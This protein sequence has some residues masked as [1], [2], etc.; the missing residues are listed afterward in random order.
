MNVW[1]DAHPSASQLPMME[2]SNGETFHIPDLVGPLAPTYDEVGVDVG[3][4][5]VVRA[6]DLRRCRAV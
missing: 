3:L 4:L 5:V 1:G 2:P 6:A